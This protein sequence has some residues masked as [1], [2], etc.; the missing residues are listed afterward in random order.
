MLYAQVAIVPAQLR[1]GKME[2]G[3]PFIKGLLLRPLVL[4]L[5]PEMLFRTL[6]QPRFPV[7]GWESVCC[8]CEWWP[9][10]SVAVRLLCIPPCARG[11]NRAH[12]GLHRAQSPGHII[13]LITV[14]SNRNRNWGMR[15][16]KQTEQEVWETESS[17]GCHLRIF[18]FACFS[19][20]NMGLAFPVLCGRPT[21][22]TVAP[23]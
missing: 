5:F 15:K 21:E 13:C 9:C 19:G 14:S 17:L 16:R 7:L 20:A 8:G 2:P 23:R 1:E 4:S 18:L 12:C 6:M 11:T 10:Q 22:T 3:G